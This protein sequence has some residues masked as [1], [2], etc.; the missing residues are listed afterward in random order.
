MSTQ[1][2]IEST[3]RDAY[4]HWMACNRHVTCSDHAS[5]DLPSYLVARLVAVLAGRTV[6]DPPDPNAGRDRLDGH[7][8]IWVIGGWSVSSHPNGISISMSTD[9]YGDGVMFREP[10][11]ARTFGIALIAAADRLASGSSESGDR[12]E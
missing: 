9:G 1:E 4:G 8:D 2:T 7:M 10:E 5:G 11:R 12:S 3:V 6:I